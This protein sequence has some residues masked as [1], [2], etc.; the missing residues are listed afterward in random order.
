MNVF[1]DVTEFL[2]KPQ[3][4]GI[5]RVTAEIC[6]RWPDERLVP[7]K[8]D[9]NTLIR[10]DRKAIGM[11]GNSFTDG[12]PGLS[13]V[14]LAGAWTKPL[15][16]DPNDILLIPELFYDSART[17]Y[18][19]TRTEETRRQF[20]FIVY[21]LIPLL[22]P[23]YFDNPP[24]EDIC[25]Y[26][27][28]IRDMPYC[29]FISEATQT[30]YYR[31]LKRSDRPGGVVLRLGSDGLGPRPLAVSRKRPPV[32]TVIGRIERHKNP[33]MIVDAFKPLLRETAGM[34][35]VFLGKFERME[36][37]ADAGIIEMARNPSS[38]LLH[39]PKPDD[40][41]IRKYI[42]ESRATVFVS[43][44]EGYG[45][46]PVESLW[47]GI[48]VIAASGIPSLEK[49]GSA[50]LHIVN[51]LS[52]DSL[53]AAIRAFLEDDYMIRKSDEALLLSTLR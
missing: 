44:A 6:R 51:P 52:A 30:T 3:L 41:T 25:S 47:R 35:L 1:I 19:A 18:Y 27:Q 13:K 33:K 4:S 48:P 53:R 39:N 38:G 5:Q 37:A 11:I 32:F 20:R 16:L 40:D 24:F 23:Q 14:A 42:D 49:I 31:R 36:I 50:G 8:F 7:V 46:P 12:L 21:D 9:G 45:L 26:F 34:Q 2:A 15:A 22:Y 28:M 17:A 29:G 10:L 43:E